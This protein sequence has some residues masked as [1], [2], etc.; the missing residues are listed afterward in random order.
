MTS[1][2]IMA[3]HQNYMYIR[4]KYTGELTNEPVGT[5][6]HAMDAIRYGIVGLH[7][8]SNRGKYVTTF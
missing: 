3:K 5:N 7:E 1:K 4:N 2:T 8:N 6:D